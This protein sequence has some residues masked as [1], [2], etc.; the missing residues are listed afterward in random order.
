[1]RTRPV[2]IYNHFPLEFGGGGEASLSL[3]ATKL[4]EAGF[5]VE[6]VTDSDYRGIT[7]LTSQQ[8]AELSNRFRY[9]RERFQDYARPG[10]KF[11][12]RRLPN[13]SELSRDAIHL[14]V[15]D[16]VPPASFLA[17]ARARGVRLGI[18]MHGLS[19]CDSPVGQHVAAAYQFYVRRALRKLISSGLLNWCSVQVFNRATLE[20]LVKSGMPEQ[21]IFEIP[22]GV[23]ISRYGPPTSDGMFNVLFMGRLDRLTK[24][25]DTLSEVIQRFV[26]RHSG[27]KIR[28]RIVGSGRDRRCLD[29]VRGLRS[30][31][32][33]G[34]IPEE[35][36]IAT[37]AASQVLVIT[38]RTEPFSMVAIEALASGA[39]VISTPVAGPT[40]IIS[41]D[42]SFGAISGPDAGSLVNILDSTFETWRRDR[43]AFDR[44]R[45]K[46]AAIAA[47]H[48]NIEV[49]VQGYSAMIEQLGVGLT[50]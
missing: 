28:F 37:L 24:G 44:M 2:R 22:T 42:P 33:D 38:S 10:M 13:A 41:R 46:R 12:F 1:M 14:L 11:L 27:D 49:M 19:P 32:I 5:N 3:L 16:R 15:I 25:I 20:F 26:E 43:Q 34:F 4:S 23:R 50:V 47:E 18:L 7:R 45:L 8:T 40:G 29:K 6:Y 36:K 9:V 48:F 31:T 35:E 30:V 17:Q 21:N 39:F